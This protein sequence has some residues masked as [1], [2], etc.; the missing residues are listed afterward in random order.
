M[1]KTLKLMC[2]HG[3]G[4]HRTSPWQAQWEA[5][6]RQGFGDA[7]VQLV[8]EFV[9]YDDIFVDYRPEPFELVRA[10]FKLGWSGIAG[11]PRDYPS[12]TRAGAARLPGSLP[13]TLATPVRRCSD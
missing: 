10:V 2:V 8:F 1:T 3:L 12:R 5:A 4:D 9:T 7:D 6:V 13:S 11:P